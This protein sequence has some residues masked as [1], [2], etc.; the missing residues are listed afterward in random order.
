MLTSG[1]AV[2]VTGRDAE[3]KVGRQEWVG[4]ETVDGPRE[5]KEK[6]VGRERG[7]KK[8]EVGRVKVG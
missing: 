7:K 1:T 8:E 2:L 3:R 5:K 4:S 6:E